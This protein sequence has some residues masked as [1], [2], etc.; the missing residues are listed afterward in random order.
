MFGQ[1]AFDFVDHVLLLSR[2][3]ITG[4]GDKGIE[5]FR[6]YLAEI[7]VCIQR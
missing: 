4:I 7:G 2:L 6:K 1:K 3:N 5:W